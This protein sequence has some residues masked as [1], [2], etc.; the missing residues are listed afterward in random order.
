[1]YPYNLKNVFLEQFYINLRV[2]RDGYNFLD[3]HLIM[4]CEGMILSMNISQNKTGAFL[5]NITI[6]CLLIDNCTLI[7]QVLLFWFS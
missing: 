5:Q 7:K 6:R 1:M 4:F 2:N 3:V